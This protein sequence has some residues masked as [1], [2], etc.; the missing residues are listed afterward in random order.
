METRQRLCVICGSAFDYA[1]DPHRYRPPPVACSLECKAKRRKQHTDKY[2]ASDAGKK[3]KI[4]YRQSEKGKATKRAWNNSEKG[5]ASRARYHASKNG[6]ATHLRYMKTEAGKAAKTKVDNLRRERKYGT[7]RRVKT[8]RGDGISLSAV[9]KRD[10]CRCQ[11]CGVKV[12]RKGTRKK[13]FAT[14]ATIDH[15][16]PL[17][18]G[19]LHEWANVQLACARC[20]FSKGAIEAI[21]QL[22]LF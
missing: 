8:E 14:M 13:V 17:A 9:M 12:R 15:I 16:K 19:G 21:G 4:A 3:G 11:L 18:L 6:K 5:K 2:R 10:K 20:N 7:N 22:R 1:Y